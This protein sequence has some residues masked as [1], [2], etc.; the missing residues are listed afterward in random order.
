MICPTR[1]INLITT[2]HNEYSRNTTTNQSEQG[3]HPKTQ[4]GHK[5]TLHSY[6]ITSYSSYHPHGTNI[7]AKVSSFEPRFTPPFKAGSFY[8]IAIPNPQVFTQQ[9]YTQILE[10]SVRKAREAII[11]MDKEESFVI[12]R[13][14][15][16]AG[17]EIRVY[18]KDNI[19]PLT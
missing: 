14:D 8:V 18:F 15:K 17:S 11:R 19:K 9:E 10:A 13:P 2:N 1:A 7:M 5:N 16:G 4:E 12:E 6:I 3:K